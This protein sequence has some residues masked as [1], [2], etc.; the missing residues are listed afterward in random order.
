MYKRQKFQHQHCK[1][2]NEI[3]LELEEQLIKIDIINRYIW[4]SL[5]LG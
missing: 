3:L 5:Y 4:R 2:I 1:I